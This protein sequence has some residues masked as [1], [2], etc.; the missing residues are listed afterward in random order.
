LF[1]ENESNV[2]K[3]FDDAASE[4]AMDLGDAF[5]QTQADRIREADE[6]Y[7]ALR[8]EGTS[9]GEAMVMRQAFDLEPAILSL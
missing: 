5:T 3:L 6:Y 2:P 7:V 4:R 1:C 8:P 9:D